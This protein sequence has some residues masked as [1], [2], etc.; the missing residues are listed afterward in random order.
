MHIRLIAVSDRQP[1]WVGDAFDEYAKRLP[2]QWRFRLDTVAT[3]HRAGN[4]GA[5]K[6]V[7]AEGL[8]VLRQLKA[9]E[10]VVLLDETGTEFTSAGLAAQLTHWQTAGRDLAFVIGG[11]DGVSAD[12]VQRAD[13]RWSLSRL[14]LPHGLARVLLVEQLYRAWTLL[15]GHPYHR[16]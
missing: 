10:Q 2:G 16:G 15:Q 4:S 7:E 13:V 9:S 1:D 6:A 8:K 11:A 3:A 5:G 14:T 12:C